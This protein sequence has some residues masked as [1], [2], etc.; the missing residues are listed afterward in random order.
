MKIIRIFTILV[1]FIVVACSSAESNHS[2]GNAV[3]VPNSDF[4]IRILSNYHSTIHNN[5]SIYVQNL[6]D[7]DA[8]TFLIWAQPFSAEESIDIWFEQR[9]VDSD[10]GKRE[11]ISINGISG[12][13]AYYESGN[14]DTELVTASVAALATEDEGIV[15][16]ARSLPEQVKETQNLL[17]SMLE[18]ISIDN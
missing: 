3:Q 1:T 13:V 15:I 6:S 18:S 8:P 14:A 4:E 5:D 10:L 16:F 9:F 7:Y 11:E 2:L 12:Y 17:L